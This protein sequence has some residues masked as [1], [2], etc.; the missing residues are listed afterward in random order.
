ML[1]GENTHKISKRPHTHTPQSSTNNVHVRTH[2]HSTRKPR[3]RKTGTEKERE[4]VNRKS[5]AEEERRDRSQT[6]PHSSASPSYPP[7][8]AD[9]CKQVRPAVTPSRFPYPHDGGLLL[10]WSRRLPLLNRCPVL[11]MFYQRFATSS[12]IGRCHAWPRS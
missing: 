10:F 8:R 12:L 1:A 4:E 11:F 7:T 5:N 3:R 9:T 2:A 6:T